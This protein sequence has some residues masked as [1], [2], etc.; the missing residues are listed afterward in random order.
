MDMP[1]LTYLLSAGVLLSSFELWQAV[2][3]N[4]CVAK[5]LCFSVSIT[6]SGEKKQHG[7][8][9]P[10]GVYIDSFKALDRRSQ[11]VL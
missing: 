5:S 1:Y 6:S 4:T 10:E 2:G 8:T 9:R 7:M 3:V 11:T